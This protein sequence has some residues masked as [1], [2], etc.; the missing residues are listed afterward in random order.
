MITAHEKKTA[1]FIHLSCLSQ[2]VIPFGNFI[3]PLLIWN[4]K[5]DN[6]DFIDTNGKQALNFQ[7]SILIYSIGIA[8]IAIP[9]I[10]INILN[11][12]PPN[13]LL[14]DNEFFFRYLEVKNI[15]GT[16]LFGILA[17]IVLIGLKLAEFFMIV[18]ASLKASEGDTYKYPLTISFL[19]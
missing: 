13:T 3:L 18:F 17:I 19:K 14:F 5:K 12:F 8:L 11:T 4:S 15:S 10:L 9:I 1:T 16:L 7:L 6:S 2:F